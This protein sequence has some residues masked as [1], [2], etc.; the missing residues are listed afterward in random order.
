MKKFVLCK[1]LLSL[2]YPYTLNYKEVLLTTL[3]TSYIAY[4]TFFASRK[5]TLSTDRKNSRNTRNTLT[6]KE[7]KYWLRKSKAKSNGDTQ[8]I[9]FI[10]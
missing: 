2:K 1:L 4:Q 8:I 9:V 7:K 5:K 6:A 10:L 3:I